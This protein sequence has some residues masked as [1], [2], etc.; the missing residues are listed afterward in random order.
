MASDESEMLKAEF[1]DAVEVHQ[2]EDWKD[3][4]AIAEMTDGVPEAAQ[5]VVEY[6]VAA[7]TE[8]EYDEV[9]RVWENVHQ[10]LVV[11]RMLYGFGAFLAAASSDDDPSPLDVAEAEFYGP[12]SDADVDG[13]VD[14]I[15]EG[16]GVFDAF[17]SGEA[18]E[19]DAE[20]GT[21]DTEE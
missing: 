3:E 12:G 4:E 10:D 9:E 2:D 13:D 16:Y 8:E 6:M 15:N 19:D 14:R 20:G 1:W 21:D 11:A 17:S 5:H 7:Y 18:G